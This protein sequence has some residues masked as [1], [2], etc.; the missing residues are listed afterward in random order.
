MPSEESVL[1]PQI[2][3]FFYVNKKKVS[4]IAARRSRSIAI[5]ANNEVFE[6]GFVGSEGK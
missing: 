3:P 4:K 5:T 6:W 2:V 1:T